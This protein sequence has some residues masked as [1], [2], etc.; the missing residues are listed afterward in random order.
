[1]KSSVLL[2]F[3]CFLVVFSAGCIRVQHYHAIPL[4]PSTTAAS[5]QART[6]C[7]PAL[8]AFLEQNL[9]HKLNPWPAKSWNLK[10]LALAALYYSPVLEQARAQVSAA[11]AAIVT[12]GARP[13]PTI[14]LQPGVPSPYLFGLDLLFS[15]QR[16]GKRKIRVEQ[17]K[18]LTLAARLNLASAAWKVRSG[19]RTALVN[20]LLATHRLGLLYLEQGLQVR[21][22][23][24]LQQ[25]LAA[26]E[27][28]RRMVDNAR[29]S[30]LQRH[31]AIEAAEGHIPESRAT[32]GAAIG[33]PVTAL[34]GIQFVWPGFERPPNAASISSELIQREAVLNRLDVRRALADYAAAQAALQ[35]QIAR[36]YPDFQ[37]GPGYH[38]EEGHNYFTV[39]Y[40]VTL[41]IFNRNQGPIAEAEAQRKEAAAAFL[42]TQANA[43]AQSE[44]ALARYQ[45]AL[46][47]L[48]GTEEALRQLEHAVIPK[49]RRTVDAGEADQLA[50]NAALL[51]RPAMAQTWLMALGRAQSALGALEDAVQRPLN[52]NEA[53][54]PGPVASHNPRKRVP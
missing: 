48:K 25:R 2:V 31:V 7:S 24:L 1:M 39:G 36:Q 32:L 53:S 41:P 34:K 51:Q 18:D 8:K 47:E 20:Y 17:A 9:G 37:I 42:A 45:G 40:S 13:N 11:K 54:W 29:L 21:R 14:R 5:L 6:L 15:I 35:L 28:S 49:E 50:L 46:G 16:A 27:I 38:F 44:E 4:S 43:I 23:K 3:L 22:V 26:G 10:M 12:A 33:I 30:L 52:P 19:V